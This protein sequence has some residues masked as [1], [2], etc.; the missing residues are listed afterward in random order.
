[1]YTTAMNIFILKQFLSDRCM[2][3]QAFA[4]CIGYTRV[5]ISSVLN[6]RSR[7]SKKLAKVI[8]NKINEM[9]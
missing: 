9:S 4:D 3:I 2:S 5:H 6:C 8:E 1:M 7:L